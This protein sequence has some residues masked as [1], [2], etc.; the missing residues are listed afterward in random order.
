ML[1]MTL[2]L[3]S[4]MTLGGYSSLDIVGCPSNIQVCTPDTSQPDRGENFSCCADCHWLK[5]LGNQATV[6]LQSYTSTSVI[7]HLLPNDDAF[8]AYQCLVNNTRMV[9]R[10]LLFVPEGECL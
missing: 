9:N 3:V 10:T 7:L 2:S 6:P 1:L 4:L 8:G 5:G